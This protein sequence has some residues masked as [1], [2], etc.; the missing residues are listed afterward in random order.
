MRGRTVSPSRGFSCR[1]SCMA[2]LL[3]V[4]CHAFD[5]A[6]ENRPTSAYLLRL[7]HQS[8]TELT[9]SWRRG[10]TNHFAKSFGRPSHSY[11]S[12]ESRTFV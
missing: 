3:V 10:L 2:G 11:L 5:E 12:T 1:R 8:R 7:P 9:L 6:F 4:P